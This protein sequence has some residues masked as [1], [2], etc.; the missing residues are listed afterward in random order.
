MD[1]GKIQV[2]HVSHCVCFVRDLIFDSN[3]TQAMT[4]DQKNLDKV[5]ASIIPGAKY[6][7][8]IYSRELVFRKRPNSQKKQV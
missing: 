3:M 4:I 2:V 7:G 5:V 1:D 8:I 6:S